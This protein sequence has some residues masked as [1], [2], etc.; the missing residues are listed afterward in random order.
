MGALRHRS[1]RRHA[2]GM[3]FLAM[4]PRPFLFCRHPVRE[5]IQQN[6]QRFRCHA[7][8][9][10][11]WPL[12]PS[13]CAAACRSPSA[14]GLLDEDTRRVGLMKSNVVKR[15]SR[16][17]AFTQFLHPIAGP[18]SERIPRL[19]VKR[20]AD[21]LES[22]ALICLRLCL[23]SV[24]RCCGRRRFGRAFRRGV[25]PKRIALQDGRLG[26]RSVLRRLFLFALLRLGGLAALTRLLSCWPRG[27]GR[28]VLAARGHSDDTATTSIKS[29]AHRVG[30]PSKWRTESHAPRRPPFFS[31]FIRRICKLA[32]HG[33][34]LAFRALFFVEQNHV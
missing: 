6:W 5:C 18:G 28:V 4:T 1:A 16:P 15:V 33:A 32:E 25:P 22:R 8:T 26:L 19:P 17:V 31:S 21:L 12:L 24:R 34:A 10:K 3:R 20:L 7:P 30:H 14:L 2:V 23:R 13:S 9:P 27:P 29:C 11:A